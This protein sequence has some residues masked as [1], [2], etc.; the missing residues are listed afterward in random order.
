MRNYKV[1]TQ[2]STETEEYFRLLSELH[3]SSHITQREL[4]VKLNISLGKTNYLLK[5]LNAK[6]MIKV[7]NFLHNPGKLRKITYLL[8]PQGFEQKVKLTHYF[9]K[10]KEEEYNYLKREWEAL[11]IAK[12]N[13]IDSFSLSFQNIPVNI[14]VSGNTVSL[15]LSTIS[16]QK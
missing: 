5:Q 16:E 3:K 12:D 8:T 6:G 7:K 2:T 9:L 13:E 10:K 11:M 14:P 4:G 1:I 15:P